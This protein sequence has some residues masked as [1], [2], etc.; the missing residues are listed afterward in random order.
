[1]LDSIPLF[2]AG[3]LIALTARLFARDGKGQERTVDGVIIVVVVVVV[4]VD[5][6]R[7]RVD[8][9]CLSPCLF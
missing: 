7:L 4:V 2:R 1:M 9:P 8:C 3:L 5:V 6:D